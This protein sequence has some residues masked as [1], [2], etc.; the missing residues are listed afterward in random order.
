M[1]PYEEKLRVR[2]LHCVHQMD[3]GGLE[4]WLMQLLRRIDRQRFAVDVLVNTPEAGAYDEEVRALGSRIIVCPAHRHPWR[5]A[6][7]FRHL[8]CKHGPYDVVHTHTH[9]FSGIVARLAYAA[10][11][12]CIIAHSHADTRH[13]DARSNPL[14]WT[15]QQVMRHW[16]VTYAT[17]GFATSV[18][19]ADALYGSDWQMDPRWR[20][21]YCGID[22]QAFSEPVDREAMRAEIGVDRQAFVLG[23]VGRLARVKNHAYLLRIA[24]I[25]AQHDPSVQLLLIGDGAER[26]SIERQAAQLGIRERVIFAGARADVARLLKGAIDV[27][28]FPS[29]AEGLGLALIEAQA[30]GLPCVIAEKIPPEAVVVPELVRR[31]GLNVPPATWATSVMEMRAVHM[32][33][34]QTAFEMVARSPFN[35]EVSVQALEETYGVLAP[36]A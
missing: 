32:P 15:Y 24:A 1:V 28:L 25:A 10:G 16:V 6:Q 17:L 35:I 14:R 36:A 23:H 20:V 9:Y 29:H 30:A 7:A 5:Y 4:T 19:A 22:L 21:L 2:I 12:P 31:L 34:A 18:N 13:A 33:T 26:C 3:R 11:V 8:L 27:F